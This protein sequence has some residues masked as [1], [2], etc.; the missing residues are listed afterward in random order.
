MLQTPNEI[1]VIPRRLGPHG[2][3]SGVDTPSAFSSVYAKQPRGLVELL[4]YSSRQHW[5]WDSRQ[6]RAFPAR[7]PGSRLWRGKYLGL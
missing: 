4:G 5:P 7:V 2:A 1:F 3:E 6:V